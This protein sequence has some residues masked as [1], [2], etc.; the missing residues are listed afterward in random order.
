MFMR[1]TSILFDIW[2]CVIPNM[3][4][5]HLLLPGAFLRLWVGEAN[6][7]TGVIPLAVLHRQDLVCAS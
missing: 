2:D 5:I 3:H 7:G 6:T 1:I 4:F